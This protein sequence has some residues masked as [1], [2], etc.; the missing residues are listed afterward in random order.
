MGGEG[1]GRR[2]SEAAELF[3]RSLA[4]AQLG[5]QKEGFSEMEGPPKRTAKFKQEKDSLAL[6]RVIYVLVMD[7]DGKQRAEVVVMF[8]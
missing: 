3:L 6:N 4:W 8:W 5:R 1:G 7:H 2:R